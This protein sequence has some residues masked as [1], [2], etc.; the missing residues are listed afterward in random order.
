MLLK[1]ERVKLGKSIRADTGVPLPVAMQMAK[2]ILRYETYSLPKKFPT[3][4]KTDVFCECCGPETFING[5]K[6]S[7]QVF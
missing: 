5:P 2:F 1:K 7:R 6:G 3:Y 4:V